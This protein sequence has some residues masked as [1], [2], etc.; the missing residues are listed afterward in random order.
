MSNTMT[1]DSDEEGDGLAYGDDPV[2][3]AQYQRHFNDISQALYFIKTAEKEGLG[4]E[5]F[6][7]AMAELFG[8]GLDSKKVVNAF[9]DAFMEWVK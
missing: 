9:R 7:A 2:A 5:V 8:G 4:F 6:D 1:L 3:A